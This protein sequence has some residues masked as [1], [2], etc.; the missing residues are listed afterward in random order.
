MRIWVDGQC[1][2]SGSSVRG[3]GRYVV[4]LLRALA[5]NRD[6][7]ITISLNGSMQSEAVAAR[8]YLARELPAVNIVIWYGLARSG[9]AHFG[10]TEERQTD[11]RILVQHINDIAPDIALSASPF[12][13][14]GDAAVAFVDTRGVICKTA[15]IFYDAIPHRYQE[16]YLNSEQKEKFYKR[17]LSSIANFDLVLC[18]SEFAFS[19]YVDIF[20]KRNAVVIGCGLSREFSNY[21]ND[22]PTA[23]LGAVSEL[24]PAGREYV[25]CVGGIDWRKNVATLVNAMARVPQCIS[26]NIDLIL[27]G[28]IKH[29]S[30]SI[31]ELWSNLGLNPDNLVLTG[32]I[33]D[34]RLVELYRGAAVVV[35]PSIMEGFGLT[36]LEAMAVGAPIL[37]GN[38]GAVPEVIERHDLLFDP[39]VAPELASKILRIMAD[40]EYRE[41]I[42]SFGYER[43]KLFSWDRTA[44]IAYESMHSLLI[45][46]SFDA[47]PLRAQF[48]PASR[49]IMDVSST[50]RSP[51]MSGIQRV[52]H[53]LSKSLV[54]LNQSRSNQTVLSYC[55]DTR[56]WFSVSEIRKELISTSPFCLLE[57]GQS[58]TYLLFDSSWG[59]IEGQRPRLTEALVQGQQVVHGIHDLGPL[60][61]PAMTDIGMPPAFRRWI[62]FVLGHST[63]VICVSRAVADEFYELIRAIKLPRPMKIGYLPLGG[64]FAEQQPDPGWLVDI[65]KRPT[66]LMVGTIEPRKGYPVAL[67]AFTKLWAEDHDINLLI[68]GKSGWDTRLLRERIAAHPEYDRRLF[69]RTGISDSQLR[70]AY[71]HAVALVMTSYLEG[72][73]LPIA[74]AGRLGCPAILSDIPVF[75]EVA[76]SGP[77]VRF[78]RLADAADLANQIREALACGFERPQS[79]TDVFPSWQASAQALHEIIFSDNWYRRYEPVEIA[80]NTKLDSIGEVHMTAA[81][82]E[83]DREHSLRCIEGPLLSD[84]GT[85]LRFV[86]AVRNEGSAI[87]S[88]YSLIGN[89]LKVN[90]GSHIYADNDIC[91]DYENPRTP[92]PFVVCPGQEVWLP[93]RVSTDWLARGA[94]EVGVELVQEAVAWFGKSLRLNIMQSQDYAGGGESVGDALTLRPQLFRGPFG[95]DIKNEQYF[96]FSAFNFSA[97]II[98]FHNVMGGTAVSVALS[99]E[100]GNALQGSW[101]VNS[102]SEIEP[103]GYGFICVYIAGHAAARA[104]ALNLRFH[105]TDGRT[106]VWE[107]DLKTLK[108]AS[109]AEPK[110]LDDPATDAR[111]DSRFSVLT[112]QT[113][114]YSIESCNDVSIASRRVEILFRADE[115]NVAVRGF[116]QP[117]PTHTWMANQEGEIN[118][119]GFGLCIDKISRLEFTVKSAEGL[120]V[121]QEVTIWLDERKLGQMV[122]SPDMMTHVLEIQPNEST[123]KVASFLRLRAL[124]ARREDGGERDLS[125]CLVRLSVVTS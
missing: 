27:A 74:E 3:I 72:F 58:D 82:S 98:R 83:Q 17:R 51:V 97:N 76:A 7:D 15:C 117:E 52:I 102:F 36:A 71:G 99:D 105:G 69:V 28:D 38:A 33:A 122:V 9:E 19:E 39:L 108:F 11:E 4:N 67:A 16:H 49:L 104:K 37:A 41:Q 46:S 89:I 124:Q 24:N 43:A 42:I 32:W 61:M 26:G 1:F 80:P 20:D 91:L 50:A 8:A 90:L 77:G 62:E 75:R 100:C 48:L 93:V 120:S 115:L 40:K 106:N 44:Q 73:G 29:A 63:G 110:P 66:F 59:F 101:L 21:L 5:S 57:M 47:V 12:E 113:E 84:D 86:I 92:V 31:Q 103:F 2:Q 18:I 79:Q 112:T 88:S 35:Q 56:G 22:V 125:I 55:Q 111:P 60:T 116:H 70:A 85:E 23:A 25:L 53:R 94:K 118:L 107:L 87:W 114:S 96:I 65:I 123:S 78:F 34:D 121:P 68:V 81:L 30:S 54:D 119:E 109:T 64:D 10:Y 95:K 14:E 13:G 6:V 45:D